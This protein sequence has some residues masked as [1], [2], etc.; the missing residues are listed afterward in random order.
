VS[1]TVTQLV[2]APGADFSRSHLALPQG[3]T[4]DEWEAVG[5]FIGSL[6]GHR[7]PPKPDR[8]L[9][10]RWCAEGEGQDWIAAGVKAFGGSRPWSAICPTPARTRVE[11]ALHR[12]PAVYWIGR[13]PV[14]YV[15]STGHGVRSRLVQ[16][17]Q[18]R[19]RAGAHLAVNADATITFINTPDR[20]AALRLEARLIR[21]LEPAL[22][23]RR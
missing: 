15:G 16:H 9:F 12:L 8:A 14:A 6:R 3:L 5:R 10:D 1:E 2:P 19:S 17:V 21:L 7:T 4:P 11:P 22:N 18:T 20:A 13:G 23:V